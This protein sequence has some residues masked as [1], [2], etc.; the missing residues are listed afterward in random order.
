CLA[1]LERYDGP[2]FDLVYLDPP[3][4]LDRPFELEA[5]SPRVGFRGEWKNG[6]IEAHCE[7][8]AA[9]T[10][11]E[12]LVRYLSFL[13]PRLVLLRERMSP[14]GSLFL[15]IGPREGPYVRML[16]DD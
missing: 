9:K 12:S 6:T 2:P 16:L 14:K 8:I 4:F 5:A 10:G 13:H 7:T 15:H 1:F 11:G 3:Y